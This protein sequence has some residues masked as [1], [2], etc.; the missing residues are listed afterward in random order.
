VF[1]ADIDVVAQVLE[2]RVVAE[3]SVVNL[4]IRTRQH[5]SHTVLL[6]DQKNSAPYCAR[7]DCREVNGLDDVLGHS[8]HKRGKDEE[9][10]EL[11]VGG[12]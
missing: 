4:L 5:R 9:E 7:C 12:L 1:R 10:Y 3:A 8:D 11:H 2:L 6:S